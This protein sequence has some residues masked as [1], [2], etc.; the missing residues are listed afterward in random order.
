MKLTQSDLE[1][2]RSNR[3]SKYNDKM[4]IYAESKMSYT[5]FKSEVVE[6]LIAEILE[7]EKE[8]NEKYPR[9]NECPF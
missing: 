2:I 3:I 6:K 7:V 5:Y 9:W 4:N 8:L 1:L